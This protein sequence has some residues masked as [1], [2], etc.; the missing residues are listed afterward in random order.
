MSSPQESCRRRRCRRLLRRC[1]HGE[2][3]AT[4][5]RRCCQREEGGNKSPI[6]RNAAWRT[7]ARKKVRAVKLIVE[8][9][10]VAATLLDLIVQ[11]QITVLI[12]SSVID[13]IYGSEGK[14][15][16]RLEK[17]ADPGCSILYL[18]NGNLISGRQGHDNISAI[19]TYDLPSSGSSPIRLSGSCSNTSD[20]LS[21]IFRDSCSTGSGF[22]VAW[23][24]NLSLENN[25]SM[26]HDTRFS[27]VFDHESLSAF[28]GKTVSHLNV[29]DQSQELHHAFHARCVEMGI[30]SVLR[31]DCKKFQDK[32]WMAIYR[33]PQVLLFTIMVLDAIQS[34][35]NHNSEAA[36]EP[37]RLLL[38]L[39]SKV[40][41]VKKTPE[42]LFCILNMHRAL[43]C[44]TP[45]LTRVFDA[46]FVTIEV[47]G[48]V[49]A[50]KDSARGMLLE[51]KVLVQTNRPQHE[52][53]QGSV[54]R[55]TEFLMTYIKVLVNHTQTLDHILCQGQDDDLLNNE[56]VNMTGRL[57]SGIIADLESLVQESSSYV[58]QR[59]KFLFLM[60]NTHF[61]LQQV[62]ESDVRLTVEPQW[63][64]K[65]HDSMKQYM[66]DYLSS[67]WKHV[68][69]PLETAT[70]S[71]HQKRL[72]NS[73]L[74]IFYPTP[75]PL[76]SFESTLNKTC[77]SQM[78]WKV[79]SPV[80]RIE[81]HTKVMEYVVQA[82]RTYWDSL[83]ESVRGGLED[84]EPNLR[85]KLSEL[86]EG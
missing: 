79:C 4:L 3:Q 56:G 41:K 50:L 83:E 37:I 63:I 61:V 10:D 19:G 66:R 69:H 35:Q 23:L 14:I 59:L 1:R 47:R 60:N 7:C 32:Q 2:T 71:S 38:S 73:F 52:P 64:K 39:A 77:K 86:L 12:L 72:R 18:H 17:Q 11:H 40:A 15:L 34:K 76:E 82:Y 68:V 29:A 65:H 81:L 24:D 28:K 62:E 13:R 67:S 84:F 33:W 55:K 42:K 43:F 6:P 31:L 51:L 74:K 49:A 36:K 46:D 70:S 30:E 57:V 21:S 9:D 80:L 48:V 54:L 75:S 26:L 25:A 8:N 20:T 27:V 5:S 53:T 85:S 22:D 45:I 16:E 78:H 58:P 44:T